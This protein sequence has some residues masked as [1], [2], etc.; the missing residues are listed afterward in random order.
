[1]A[2]AADG[3]LGDQCADLEP[4]RVIGDHKGF[5]D[6]HIVGVAGSDQ[7]CDLVS[8]QSNRLFD[9]HVLSSLSCLDRPFDMLRRGQRDVDA[10]DL[11][12]CQKLLIGGKCQR[13]AE[14]V[15]QRASAGMITAGNC[16]NHAVFRILQLRDHVV[17]A[18]L[19]GRQNSPSKHTSLPIYGLRRP[20]SAP[21]I[22]CHSSLL[23]AGCVNTRLAFARGLKEEGHEM[24]LGRVYTI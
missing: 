24:T 8:V 7:R 4:L 22:N 14:P 2:Q 19:G 20:F 1:M 15:G 3:A 9:Q 5:A 10:L 23:D 17:T 13:H 12:R 18:D 6:Q 21:S 16:R 11:W